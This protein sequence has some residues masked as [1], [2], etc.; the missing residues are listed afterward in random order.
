MFKLTKILIMNN[1]KY[2][3]SNKYLYVRK[4]KNLKI[5]VLQQ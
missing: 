3:F 2:N 4:L 1:S 5:S